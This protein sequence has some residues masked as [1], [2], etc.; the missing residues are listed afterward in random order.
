VLLL[1]LPMMMTMMD[2]MSL[3]HFLLQFEQQYVM[4]TPFRL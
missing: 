1:L 2:A 4:Q 3:H